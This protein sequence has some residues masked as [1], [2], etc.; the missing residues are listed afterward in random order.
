MKILV[1]GHGGYIGSILTQMLVQSGH[2]VVG[3]DIRP[4]C[5]MHLWIE[6]RCTNTAA[7]TAT[8]ES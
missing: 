8:F 4:L 1:T 6:R 3:I 2:Q 7:S 5:E